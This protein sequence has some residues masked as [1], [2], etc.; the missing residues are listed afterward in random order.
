M[1]VPAQRITFIGVLL[2]TSNMSA[3]LSQERVERFQRSLA[4]FQV[5]RK[6]SYKACMTLAGMMASSVFLLRL[7]RFLYETVFN[8]G[9]CLSR[10][11]PP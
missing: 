3:H 7:G 9:C 2:D 1:L 10:S 11:H 6:V 4:P 5:G 8:G